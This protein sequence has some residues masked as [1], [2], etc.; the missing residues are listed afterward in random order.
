MK[1]AIHGSIMIQFPIVTHHYSFRQKINK[2]YDIKIGAL[3]N[4]RRFNG[5]RQHFKINIAMID[6]MSTYEKYSNHD[7]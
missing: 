3:Q 4:F 7:R 6:N 1:L 2:N 5:I